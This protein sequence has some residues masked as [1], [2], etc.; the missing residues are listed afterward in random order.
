MCGGKRVC[1]R[2]CTCACVYI[3]VC[4][5]VCV[6]IHVRG[7]GVAGIRKT[8]LI[9]R[10]VQSRSDVGAVTSLPLSTHACRPCVLVCL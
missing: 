2:A 7:G 8:L 3:N 6:C 4:L 5:C 9:D 10:P 1:V